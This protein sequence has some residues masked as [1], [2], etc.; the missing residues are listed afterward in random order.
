MTAEMQ[1]SSPEQQLRA[2]QPVIPVIFHAATDLLVKASQQYENFQRRSG[3]LFTRVGDATS[4][5][6]FPSRRKS[7]AGMLG[8]IIV[9]SLLLSACGSGGTGGLGCIP[10]AQA[11]EIMAGRYEVI[12]TAR[13][14]SDAGA[15]AA[16]EMEQKMTANPMIA[17]GSKEDFASQT[18]GPAAT[19]ALFQYGVEALQTGKAQTAEAL[20]N[21]PATQTAAPGATQTAKSDFL[22]AIVGTETSVAQQTPRP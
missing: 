15:T 20:Q 13:A 2:I 10:P 7:V 17:C 9:G 3:E 16:A 8:F 21:A 18:A 11:T 19:D 6:R 5:V 4:F 1:V 12:A 22:T 14:T